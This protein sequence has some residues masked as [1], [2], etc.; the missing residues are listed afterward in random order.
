M[1]M[2]LD[3]NVTDPSSKLYDLKVLIQNSC[4]YYLRTVEH[5]QLHKEVLLNKTAFNFQVSINVF[6]LYSVSK[7]A[8]EKE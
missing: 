8:T 7:L 4:W 5:F 6:N 2:R 1:V 3:L